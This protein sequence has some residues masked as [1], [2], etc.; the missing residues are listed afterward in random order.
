M[1]MYRAP[2]GAD[3]FR[4]HAPTPAVHSP[5]T[6]LGP[7]APLHTSGLVVG[8]WKGRDKTYFDYALLIDSDPF[9]I[10]CRFP[11]PDFSCSQVYLRA[12]V[13]PKSTL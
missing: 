10:L 8:V 4:T 13:A 9:Q 5:G 2:H 7:L 3:D 12:S 6:G 11:R 1:E